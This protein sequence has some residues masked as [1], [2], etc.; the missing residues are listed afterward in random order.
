MLH[1][2]AL[3]ALWLAILPQLAGASAVVQLGKRDEIPYG[4]VKPDTIKTCSFWYDNWDGMS[5]QVVRDYLFAIPAETFT[6]WNPSISLDCQGWEDWYSYC[7][8]VKNEPLPQPSKS[9]S[10]TTSTPTPTPTP[11]VKKWESLGCYIDDQTLSHRSTREGG[12]SLTVDKCEAA[13]W[14]D[15]FQYAGVKSGTQCWCGSFVGGDWA[16]NQADCNIPC[17]GNKSQMCGGN[18]LLLVFEA[19][20]D[21]APLPPGN[22]PDPVTTTT[23]ASTSSTSIPTTTAAP[24][25]TEPTWI[26]QGCHKDLYPSNARTLRELAFAS[27]TSLTPEVCQATCLQNGKV[28]SGVEN[29]RECWCGDAIQTPA[30]N[31]PTLDS[32][33]SKPC[34]GDKSRTCGSGGRIFL[35]RYAVPEKEDWRVVGCYKDLWPGKSRTLPDQAYIGSELYN[36]MCQSLCLERGKKLAGTE[37]GNECWCGD[38]IQDPLDNVWVDSADCSTPCSGR[39]GEMCGAGARISLYQYVVPEKKRWKDIGCHKD[40][41]PSTKRTLDKQV[42]VSDSELT[43]GGCQALCAREGTKYAG[44]EN[45]RECWCG[46]DIQDSQSNVLVD[47][48]ECQAPCSGD[49]AQTCGSGARIHLYEF[50]V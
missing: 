50:G 5:C 15:G 41:F 28:L 47:K 37:N 2:F 40:L 39:L 23:T 36:S 46:N 30:S 45:G 9:S 16:Q 3:A 10:S 31:T 29:G 22:D 7:V 8:E 19:I 1:S 49:S 42:L 38:A 17:P 13:C 35:Y 6:R 44:L 48:A 12:N 24:P 43:I 11:V 14:E 20:I 26:P 4:E 32:E 34:S 25:H 18:K 33:C 27:D 21:S